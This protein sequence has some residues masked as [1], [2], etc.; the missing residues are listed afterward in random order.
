MYCKG[1]INAEVAI[2]N[3]KALPNVIQISFHSSNAFKHIKSVTFSQLQKSKWNKWR[4]I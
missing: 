1:K 2:N 4:L 3:V